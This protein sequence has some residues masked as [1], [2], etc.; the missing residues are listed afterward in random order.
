MGLLVDDPLHL[1]YHY[2]TLMESPIGKHYHFSNAFSD[3]SDSAS[4]LSEPKRK[5]LLSTILWESDFLSQL[6]VPRLGFILTEHFDI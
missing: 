1:F 2:V 4:T 6:L 3:G 5:C